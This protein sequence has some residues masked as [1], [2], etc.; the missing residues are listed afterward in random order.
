M[1]KFECA[2]AIR[3]E[4]RQ[5]NHTSL[6]L[7]NIFA[8]LQFFCLCWPS[9]IDYE[10]NMMSHYIEEIHAIKGCTKII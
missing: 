5:N 2:H 1:F 4:G 6:K 10:N 7:S 8:T 9:C 3:C